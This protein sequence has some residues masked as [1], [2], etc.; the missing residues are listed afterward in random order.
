MDILMEKPHKESHIRLL[1]E[2]TVK[3]LTVKTKA[4]TEPSVTL[5]TPAVNV[6]SPLLSR[7]SVRSFWFFIWYTKNYIFHPSIVHQ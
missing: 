1:S 7:P 5:I 3:S 4:N 6:N 2:P